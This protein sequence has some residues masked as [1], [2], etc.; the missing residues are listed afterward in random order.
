ML[1]LVLYFELLKLD[2]KI[3]NCKLR[4]SLFTHHL[5]SLK[6]QV[7]SDSNLVK[8]LITI[9]MLIFFEHLNNQGY[10]FD[11][12]Y[13]LARNYYRIA[14]LNSFKRE[15]NNLKYDFHNSDYPFF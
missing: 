4:R 13:H 6:S 15:T 10:D 14:Q 12:L 8:Y 9:M 5:N 2:F 3:Q 1:F 11:R 7:K